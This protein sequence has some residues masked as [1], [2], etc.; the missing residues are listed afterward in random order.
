MSLFTTYSPKTLWASTTKLVNGMFHVPPALPSTT[1]SYFK[2]TI[3]AHNYIQND[4]KGI[5]EK[6]HVDEKEITIDKI[7]DMICELEK[8]LFNTE[9]E[10]PKT[11]EGCQK[12][13][14]SVHMRLNKTTTSCSIH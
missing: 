10:W 1:T 14:D 7:H 9:S 12:Y 8:M 3:I 11:I 5:F 13:T 2:A 4:L 6:I